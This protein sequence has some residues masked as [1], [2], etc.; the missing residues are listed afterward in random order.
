M[1]A[2]YY[3][4]LWIF[5]AVNYCLS[6]WMYIVIVKCVSDA[7]IRS[8][9]RITYLYKDDSYCSWTGVTQYVMETGSANVDLDDPSHLEGSEY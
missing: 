1:S 4:K 8:L 6:V 5:S 3:D 7:F 2:I 9:P